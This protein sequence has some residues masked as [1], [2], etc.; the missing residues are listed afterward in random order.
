MGVARE[1]LRRG[2]LGKSCGVSDV[3]SIAADIVPGCSF[4][5]QGSVHDH[6]VSIMYTYGTKCSQLGSRSHSPYHTCTGVHL[7]LYLCYAN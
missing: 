6:D 5:G 1:L 3:K 4:V 2:A 7:Y